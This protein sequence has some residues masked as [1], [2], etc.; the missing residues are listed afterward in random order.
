MNSGRRILCGIIGVVLLPALVFAQSGPAENAWGLDYEGKALV[1]VLPLAGESEM[2]EPF[3][4]ET[5]K[6][7]EALEKYHPQEVSAALLSGRGIEIPTDMPPSRSLAAGARYAL[8][9]GVYPGNRPGEFYLQLWLWNMAGSTM[10]YTDD[11]LYSDINDAMASLPGLVEWLFSHIRETAPQEPETDTRKDPFFM[12]G[13]RAGLS[14]KRYTNPNEKSPGASSLGPEGGISGALRL[15]SLL[16]LQLDLLFSG[17]T[18][19]YRGLRQEKDGSFVYYNERLSTAFLTL[20]LVLKVNFRPGSFRLSPLAG[21]YAALPLGQT[22]FRENP[23]GKEQSYS[24]SAASLGFTAG[25]EAAMEYGP[26]MMVAGLRYSGDFNYMAI[27][28]NN[29]KDTAGDTRYRRNIFSV[30]VGYEFGFFDTKK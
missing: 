9:G 3:Q 2:A 6:A 30:Y 16:S 20:P 18:L 11:L 4:Q 21:F 25:F 22:A 10:I 14:S 28:Y 23:G 29:P 1:A 26:G 12:L 17:D 13:P 19:V 24:H 8:T 5:M 27:D 7:V 15:S